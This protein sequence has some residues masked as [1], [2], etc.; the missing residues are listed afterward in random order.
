MIPAIFQILQSSHTTSSKR[1]SMSSS[2]SSSNS[3]PS[4]SFTPQNNPLSLPSS[5]KNS[6][7]SLKNTKTEQETDKNNYNQEPLSPE[8]CKYKLLLRFEDLVNKL[9]AGWKYH[10]ANTEGVKESWSRFEHFYLDLCSYTEG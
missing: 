5:S 4:S 7:S 3:A 1:L 8:L 9:A 6:T 2:D 10:V